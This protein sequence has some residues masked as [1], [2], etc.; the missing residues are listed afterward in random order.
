MFF[1][2]DRG[3]GEN[4]GSYA[5]KRIGVEVPEEK[6]ALPAKDAKAGYRRS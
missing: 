1:V 5:K 2:F 6:A 4:A 3:P